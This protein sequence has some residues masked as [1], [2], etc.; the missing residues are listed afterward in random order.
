[1]TPRLSL[2]TLAACALL[3]LPVPPA[4]AEEEAAD[5]RTRVFL[6]PQVQPAWPG[7]KKMAFRPFADISRASEGESFEFEAP[8]E[9][10][11]LS[12]FRSRGFEVGPVAGFI[13]KRSA[14]DVGADLPKVGFTVEAGAFAQLDAAPGI[15]LRL[16]GRKGLSGH[17][18][19]VGEASADY[20]ARRGDDW[21]VS[22]GPRVTFGDRRYHRAWFGVTPDVAAR[23]GLDA[24]A[25]GGGIQS[26]GVTAGTLYQ[27]DAKWGVA[28]FARYDRLVGDAAASPVTRAFGTRSQPSAGIALSR[29]FGGAR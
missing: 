7:A 26:V 22:V 13:G 15:R 24:F 9:S 28:A 4:A 23:T 1:M 12:L 21:L 19:W 25:P 2:C 6:G 14:A 5:K 3:V 16:E 20:V 17:K 27:I 18:G 8:D 11:G 10:A 29:I